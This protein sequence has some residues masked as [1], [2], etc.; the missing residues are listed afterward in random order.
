M[1]CGEHRQKE[2]RRN[3][4]ERQGTA[5]H[6]SWHAVPCHETVERRLDLGPP[7]PPVFCSASTPVSGSVYTPVALSFP[8]PRQHAAVLYADVSTLTSARVVLLT[9]VV[10]GRC[11]G[12]GS[13]GGRSWRRSRWVENVHCLPLPFLHLPLPF[14][15]LPSPSFAVFSL[16]QAGRRMRG[17]TTRR[18]RRADQTRRRV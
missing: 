15:H 2:G 10:A 9:A 17:A 11:A 4:R 13:G 16:P 1:G 6:G 5:C 3:E 7:K 8:S 12:G 18:Q 14:L